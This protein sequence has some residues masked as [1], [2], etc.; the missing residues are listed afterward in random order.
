MERVPEPELMNDAEQARAYAGADFALP[1][2]HF[3]EL[4]CERFPD[5]EP[6]FALELGCG[7]GDIC[8]RFARTFPHSVVHG[9][10]G[11]E[12]MLACGRAALRASGLEGR[13]ELV[14]G[15]LP[16][17]A[18][19]RDRY[20]LVFSNSLLHH[21]ADPRVLWQSAL[22]FAERNAPLFVMDLLR[23]ASRDEAA[24]LCQCYAAGEPPILQRDFEHSLLAAY[25]PD[26][27]RAQLVEVGLGSLSVEVVSDRHLIVW[28]RMPTA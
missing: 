21:L 17:D 18:P 16:A 4:L 10:D 3:I 28:G 22:R 13:V 1:H 26:E 24:S 7:A 20:D 14:R 8:M 11:A 6:A 9:V 2:Q 25:R 12:A 23:P 19:P 15:Y 27:V 5:E